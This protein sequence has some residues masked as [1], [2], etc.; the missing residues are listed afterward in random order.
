MR[1]DALTLLEYQNHLLMEL[2]ITL[3]LQRMDG[4]FIENLPEC[5][6]EIILDLSKPL[7]RTYHGYAGLYRKTLDRVPLI[8]LCQLYYSERLPLYKI[9]KYFHIHPTTLEA[10]LSAYRMPKREL[11]L[12]KEDVPCKDFKPEPDGDTPNR[13]MG[14]TIAPYSDI[15]KRSEV[16]SLPEYQKSSPE[17]VAKLIDDIISGKRLFI[18]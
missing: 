18:Y 15:P 14:A 10:I 8:K 13:K 17:K 7:A 2:E 3:I 11:Q 5:M 12:L 6:I 9:C 16:I 4:A 1:I